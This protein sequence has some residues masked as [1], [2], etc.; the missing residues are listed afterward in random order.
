MDEE[1]DTHL[2]PDFQE[3]IKTLDKQRKTDFKKTFPELA[4]LL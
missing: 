3:Y 4:H 1:D 2:L